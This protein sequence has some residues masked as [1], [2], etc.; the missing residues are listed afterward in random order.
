MQLPMSLR[1]RARALQHSSK[2]S[3][4]SNRNSC[5]SPST[6][7]SS[8]S[9]I[10]LQIPEMSKSSAQTSIAASAGDI[11]PFVLSFFCFLTLAFS[12]GANCR[13]LHAGSTASVP[14]AFVVELCQVISPCA[15]SQSF[16]LLIL[17]HQD[18]A[19]GRCTRGTSCRF[20]CVNHV[21]L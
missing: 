21:F 15:L 6:P 2:N 20:R 13:F 11:Y 8:S 10:S 16:L 19:R 1:I 18:F 14:G 4:R 3:S 17:C 7:S 12:R 5:N 9:S